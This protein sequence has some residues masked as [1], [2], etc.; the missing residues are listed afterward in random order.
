MATVYIVGRF[1]LLR[2]VGVLNVVQIEYFSR[3]MLR[4][5]IVLSSRL[6]RKNLYTLNGT[7]AV[8]VMRRHAFL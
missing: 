3:G 1:R 7:H 2:T 4:Q 8:Q 5:Q 6:S